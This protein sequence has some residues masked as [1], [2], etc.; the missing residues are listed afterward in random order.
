[1]KLIRKCS[2]VVVMSAL[3]CSGQT[4]IARR[5]RSEA[6]S[7][8]RGG[9]TV[10]SSGIRGSSAQGKATAD[11]LPLSLREVVERGLKFNLALT[12]S[13]EDERVRRAQRLITLSRLLPDLSF[14]PSASVQQV[15]LAAF[16]FTGFT[17]VPSIVGPFGLVDARA[18]VTQSLLDLRQ[19]RNLKAD[20]ESEVVAVQL[21]ADLRGKVVIFVSGLYLQSLAARARVETQQIQVKTAETILRQATDRHDAG[22]VPRIDVLRVQ[23]Q[24]DVEQN[25]LIA[26]EGEFEKRKIDMA[27]AI[28]LPSGQQ[29]LLTDSMPDEALPRDVTIEATLEQ[30]YAKRADFH[31]AQAAVRA[32]EYARSAALAGRY[33]TADA[34]AN[35]G[36][37][38]PAIDHV[39]GTFAVSVGMNIPI[40]QGGRTKAEVEVADSLLRRRK[41]EL[42]DLRGRI[43]AEVRTAFT[44]VRTAARQVEVATRSAGLAR[45][46]LSESQDRFSAGVTNNLEVVQAQQAVA[47]ANEN[48]IGALFSL[49]TARASFLLAR[50][51]AEQAMLE[52]VRRTK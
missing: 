44:D 22:T 34:E 3:V 9:P 50:G 31:A 45:E 35:Y 33:P 26:F 20:R 46:Q 18:S 28:G 43:E 6:S 29:I 13:G 1:M 10:A 4:S 48:Y 39:H 15:N 19:M 30:A 36:L 16:G 32:S 42:D 47:V 25:R 5:D 51:D 23:V 27:R 41:A 40:F 38:G 21:G 14:R 52:F 49:N 7:P 24:L 12:E 37:N 8:D 2:F 17:G 11:V